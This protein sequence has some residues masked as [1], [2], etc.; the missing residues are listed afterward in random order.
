MAE[1]TDYVGKHLTPSLQSAPEKNAPKAKITEPRTTRTEARQPKITKSREIQPRAARQN[2]S[3]RRKRRRIRRRLYRALLI[4]LT[5]LLVFSA[6]MVARSLFRGDRLKGA[7]MLDRNTVYE[8]DGKGDGTLRLPLGSYAFS[9]TVEYNVVTLDF[10]D[11]A[12]TDASYSFL[13]D[14]KN[15]TLDTNTGTV[16]RLEKEK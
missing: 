5:I 1:R 16:Y 11:A 15:L 3:R 10:E 7:W 2:A 14:G 6:A 8:F 13:R 12:I 9:Y 4:V